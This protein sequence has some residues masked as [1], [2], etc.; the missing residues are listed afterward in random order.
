MPRSGTRSVAH[1]PALLVHPFRRSDHACSCAKTMF[2][3]PRCR[4][5]R[6]LCLSGSTQGG[7]RQAT[8]ECARAWLHR[9]MGQ[10]AEWV[11]HEASALRYVCRNGTG[12][13]SHQ[14]A[15]RRHQALLGSQQLA[16]ALLH[17]SQQPQAEPGARQVTRLDE[18]SREISTRIFS[19]TERPGV[20]KKFQGTEWDRR[21]STTQDLP[22]IG[23]IS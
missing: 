19:S 11:S 3:R 2:M 18:K 21:G 15:S 4:L 10:G 13:R 5:W 12:C 23:V 6:A 16:V 9:R 8:T 20:V 14:T 1:P 7:S 22:E 17:L